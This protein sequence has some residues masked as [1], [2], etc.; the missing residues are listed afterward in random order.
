MYH[1]IKVKAFDHDSNCDKYASAI[2]NSCKYI[3]PS[4]TTHVVSLLQKLKARLQTLTETKKT[5]IESDVKHL[6]NKHLNDVSIVKQNKEHSKNTFPEKAV[7]E[8]KQSESFHY[9]S[10]VFLL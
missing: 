8:P 2:V 1:R 5:K 6:P 4:K 7:H 3:H 9:Q 10:Q